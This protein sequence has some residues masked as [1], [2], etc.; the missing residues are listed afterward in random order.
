M[1]AEEHPTLRDFLEGYRAKVRRL[2]PEL[3][4]PELPAQGGDLVDFLR[5]FTV[6]QMLAYGW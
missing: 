6:E 2:A 3:S 5:A 1:Y 4:V